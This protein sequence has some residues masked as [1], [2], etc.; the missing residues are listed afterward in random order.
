MSGQAGTVWITGFG[1][2]TGV[3]SNPTASLARR[4]H[5]EGGGGKA[6]VLDVACTAVDPALDV[7]YTDTAARDP[8]DRPCAVVH[9]GV[10]SRATAIRVEVAAYNEC[11]FK[12]PDQDGYLPRRKA[13]DPS[14]PLGHR[15][16]TRYNVLVH[17]ATSLL[18]CFHWRVHSL[19]MFHD[20]NF[21]LGE[22]V[23]SSVIM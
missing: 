8:G 6:M 22:L 19:S 21:Q 17:G 1:P 9:L 7:I 14:R 15:Q 11:D 5:A 12:V 13:I 10:D 3:E 2:F 16:D 4:W 18:V 20:L 23:T